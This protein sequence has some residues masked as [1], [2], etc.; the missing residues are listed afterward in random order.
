MS[1]QNGKGK[2]VKNFD[3]DYGDEVEEVLL[4][5]EQNA[6][7]KPVAYVSDTSRGIFIYQ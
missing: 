1:G 3:F 4:D 5:M 6:V 2:G 7:P